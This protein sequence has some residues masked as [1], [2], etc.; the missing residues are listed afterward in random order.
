M[1]E[2]KARCSEIVDTVAAGGGDLVI[3]KRG[4]PV[5]RL[6]AENL[7]RT[8]PRGSWRGLV[9]VRGD[10]VE[11]DWSDEFEASRE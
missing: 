11:T 7:R 6:T 5:A 1:S 9:E 2:F 4:V 3:T 10:V 8:S